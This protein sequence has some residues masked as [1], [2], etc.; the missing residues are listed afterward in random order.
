MSTH[1]YGD[2]FAPFR[3][4]VVHRFA[5]RYSAAKRRKTNTQKDEIT[6]KRHTKKRFKEITRGERTK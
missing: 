4:F 6:E 2:W 1:N 3:Y 5:W